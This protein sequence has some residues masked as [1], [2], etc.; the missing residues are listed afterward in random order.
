MPDHR[1]CDVVIVGAGP[2]G[3]SA[4][5][6]V[7]RLGLDTVLLER[8]PAPGSRQFPRSAVLTPVPGFVSGRRLFDGLF[9]PSLDFLVPSSLI[10]GYP[11]VQKFIS[12][13]GYAFSACFGSRA[14]FPAAVV[15]KRGLLKLLAEQ[16]QS[17]GA[18]LQFETPVVGLLVESG[19]VVGVRTENGPLRAQ[20]VMAVEGIARRL[21]EEGDLYEVP[22]PS[23]TDC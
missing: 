11:P 4:A 20:V 13:S 9:F 21:C 7:A 19:Q 15:D 18:R 6:T 14:G 3:L 23:S 16:A 17:A 22:Y 12:P 5:R 2:A 8:M 10:L 1:Q